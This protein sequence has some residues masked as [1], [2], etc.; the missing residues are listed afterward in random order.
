ME[1][2]CRLEIRFLLYFNVLN[3][4][5]DSVGDLAKLNLDISLAAA[6]ALC[7][8]PH[9]LPQGRAAKA[10]CRQGLRRLPRFDS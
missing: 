2:L 6:S 10:A 3:L 5:P 4:T 1:P 7:R 8:A 9:G